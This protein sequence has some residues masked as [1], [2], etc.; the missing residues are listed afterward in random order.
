MAVF[1]DNLFSVVLL[2]PQ[3]FIPTYNFRGPNDYWYDKA[4]HVP[5]LLKLCTC[6]IVII[7]I[8]I[9]II[10]NLLYRIYILIYPLIHSFSFRFPTGTCT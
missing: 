10:I 3:F 4:F 1:V 6:N 9:I 2:F 7:I 5:H 8:I